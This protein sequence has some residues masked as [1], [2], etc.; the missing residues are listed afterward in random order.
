VKERLIVLVRGVE[1][2]QQAQ[3]RRPVK[4]GEL[5]FDIG[6][7]QLRFRLT[8][9]HKSLRSWRM[10]NFQGSCLTQKQ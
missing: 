2:V 5:G 9:C 7:G 1:M 10:H 4:G 3:Q 8:F 6:P